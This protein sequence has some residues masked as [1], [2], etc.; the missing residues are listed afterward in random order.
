MSQHCH[1][2]IGHLKGEEV[3]N[4]H[5]P[6][7]KKEFE[8]ILDLVKQREDYEWFD[9]RVKDLNTTLA[10][11]TTL[12]IEDSNYWQAKYKDLLKKFEDKDGP[13]QVHLDPEDI[14]PHYWPPQQEID[15]LKVRLANSSQ[16]EIDKIRDVYY[17]MAIEGAYLHAL[18][19]SEDWKR[20]PWRSIA[21]SYH[22]FVINEK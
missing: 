2:L 7:T 13:A 22:T 14:G 3:N 12:L 10:S 18:L 21:V 19:S 8:H 5:S 1:A 20:H 16:E 11:G 6:I 15:D 4:E 9:P 17:S